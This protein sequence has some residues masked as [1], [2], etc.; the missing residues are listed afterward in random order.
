MHNDLIGEF[1]SYG[2]AQ[3]MRIALKVKFWGTTVT[4][5]R[6]LT[7]R[8]DTFKMQH[9]DSMQEHW[10]KISAMVCELKVARNNLTE[11]Q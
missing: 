6:A 5:L 10:R 1:E 2:I 9:G 11:E 8:F 4:W 3:D 7:L